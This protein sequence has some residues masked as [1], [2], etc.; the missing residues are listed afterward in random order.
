MTAMIGALQQEYKELYESEIRRRDAL[1]QAVDRP[2]AAIITAFVGVVYFTVANLR[3]PLSSYAV[4][5]LAV[6]VLA[7]LAIAVSI[8]FIIRSYWNHTYTYIPTPQQLADYREK[9]KDYYA[10]H[11]REAHTDVDALVLAFIYEGYVRGAHANAENNRIRSA[12]LHKAKTLLI[13]TLPLV[14]ALGLMKATT[15]LSI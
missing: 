14:I 6:A 3:R 2:V 13:F 8:Y 12:Y 7:I 15:A 5:Q 11:L 4:F 1:N 9:L 10:K